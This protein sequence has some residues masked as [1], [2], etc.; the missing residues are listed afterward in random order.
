MAQAYWQAP[1]RPC[2]RELN[3]TI[4]EGRRV[5]ASVEVYQTA[6][7]TVYHGSPPLPCYFTGLRLVCGQLQSSRRGRAEAVR[8]RELGRFEWLKSFPPHARIGKSILLY[9]LPD[10]PVAP[11]DPLT[12]PEP[13]S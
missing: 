1:R 12:P 5:T 8:L 2:Y 6:G 3:A 9:H 10:V 11:Q 13:A 4:D 7:F